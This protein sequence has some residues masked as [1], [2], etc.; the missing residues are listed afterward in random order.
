[1][2][3]LFL[4]I[5]TLFLAACA[6]QNPAPFTPAIYPDANAPVVVTITS[7]DEF[8]IS[9]HSA[10]PVYTQVFPTELLPLIDWAPCPSLD[11]CAGQSI[12][13]GASRTIAFA[14]IAER[15]TESITVF[16]WQMAGDVGAPEDAYFFPQ[17][18]KVVVP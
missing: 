15:D 14:D 3:R 17:G 13:P 11:A 6:A 2:R 16:W 1:M 10:A 4:F 8:T 5:T 9:N 12:A 18:I 7:P